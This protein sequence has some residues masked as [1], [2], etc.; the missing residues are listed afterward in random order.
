MPDAPQF[1]ISVN[2][3]LIGILFIKFEVKNDDTPKEKAVSIEDKKVD[4]FSVTP[5]FFNAS[6]KVNIDNI[7]GI[8]S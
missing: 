2:N 3:T 7:N 1:N 8:N 5:T 6:T 4:I